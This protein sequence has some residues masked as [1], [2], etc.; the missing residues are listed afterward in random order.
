MS[1]CASLDHFSFD[2]IGTGI[3]VGIISNGKIRRG[4]DGSARDIG[5]ICVEKNDLLYACG[6]KCC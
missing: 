3:G 2:K 4:S 5:H 6:N 1:F